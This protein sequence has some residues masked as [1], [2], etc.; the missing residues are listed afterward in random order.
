MLEGRWRASFYDAC[1]ACVTLL[2][3]EEFETAIAM[4]SAQQAIC[5]LR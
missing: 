4:N 5:Y 1:I 3:D 2:N